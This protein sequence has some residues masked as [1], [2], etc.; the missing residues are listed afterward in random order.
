MNGTRGT[1][2]DHRARFWPKAPLSRRQGAPSEDRNSAQILRPGDV[3]ADARRLAENT[4][5]AA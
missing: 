2:A 1:Q 5:V 4:E 3:I